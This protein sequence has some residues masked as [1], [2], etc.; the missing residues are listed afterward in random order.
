MGLLA[1]RTGVPVVPARVFGS[2]HAFGKDG[3]LRL[4]TPVTVVFGQPLQPF[5]YDDPA[6]GKE[7]YLLASQRIMAAIAK[8][9]LPA[10]T[11]V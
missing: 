9:E 2:F 4:G 10:Q 7:R 5:E 11:V 3:T 8:L 1:C 6:A